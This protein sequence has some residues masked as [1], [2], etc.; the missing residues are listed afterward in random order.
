MRRRGI[1]IREHRGD[2]P[3]AAICNVKSEIQNVFYP[4]ASSSADSRGV[5]QARQIT[6]EQSPQTSG[7]STLRAQL[8]Q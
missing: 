2:W 6:A 5:P 3:E 8:G 1:Q 7:S 4:I